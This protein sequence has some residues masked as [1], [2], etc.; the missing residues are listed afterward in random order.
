MS[1]LQMMKV[2]MCNNPGYRGGTP[3]SCGREWKA[4]DSGGADRGVENK[5]SVG[6]EWLLPRWFGSTR[7]WV[8]I[9]ATGRRGGLMG[10][11][12]FVRMAL[13]PIII[14]T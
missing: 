10:S 11:A 5:N 14:Y 7:D 4:G 3:A 9:H 2:R 13:G 1:L 12:Q 6:F 8:F